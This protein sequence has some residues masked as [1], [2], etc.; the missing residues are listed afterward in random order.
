MTDPLNVLYL[1]GSVTFLSAAVFALW[2]YRNTSRITR[3]WL[4]IAVIG[5]LGAVWTGSYIP[6]VFG[7]DLPYLASARPPLATLSLVGY[8]VSSVLAFMT[9]AMIKLL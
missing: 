6:A 2:N 4:V 7:I 9:D 5:V 8:T 1:I 3:Y